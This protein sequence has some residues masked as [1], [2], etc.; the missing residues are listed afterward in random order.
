MNRNNDQRLNNENSWNGGPPPHWNAHP[1][2]PQPQPNLPPH[3]FRG[4][5]PQQPPPR[6]PG[7]FSTMM[8]QP[9]PPNMMG[10][11][12]MN[13]IAPASIPPGMGPPQPM[14]AVN[15]LNVVLPNNVNQ[16]SPLISPMSNQQF[17]SS[18]SMASSNINQPQPPYPPAPSS[19]GQYNAPTGNTPDV[20]TLSMVNQLL[21]LNAER[22]KQTQNSG[23]HSSTPDNSRNAS[24]PSSP[25]R[26]SGSSPTRSKPTSSLPPHWKTATDADGRVY[27]YHT[28]T[29]FV[30][31][32]DEPLI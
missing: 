8:G 16:S 20:T 9:P 15:A 5:E 23:S 27:Y 19:G 22:L 29:R 18:S 28:E 7:V 14:Q 31:A 6:P 26:T 1:Q 17:N 11:P 21:L 32:V 10:Q 13:M 3:R 25:M 2:P 12:P 30:R 24:A 4:N